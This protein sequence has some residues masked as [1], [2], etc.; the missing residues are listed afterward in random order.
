MEKGSE[1]QLSVAGTDEV[2]VTSAVEKKNKT[3]CLCG[4]HCRGEKKKEKK[5]GEETYCECI[6]VLW[7]Y[8]V[9]ALTPALVIVIYASTL[10]NEVLVQKE[11]QKQI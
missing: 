1:V 6:V 8:C 10:E 4:A 3:C 11:K 7:W 2:K 9:R 5:K